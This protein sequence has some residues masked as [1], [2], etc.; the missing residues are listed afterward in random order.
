MPVSSLAR[1]SVYD[2]RIEVVSP[3]SPQL[4]SIQ[5]KKSDSAIALYHRLDISVTDT[6]PESADN[7]RET[8]LSWG[9]DNYR[10][11]PW[12][13]A[14]RSVY[15]VFIAEFFLTQTPADNVADVYPEFLEKYP[16]VEVLHKAD[17]GKIEST[18][19]P[20]GFQ[21]MRTE[22]LTQI[23]SEHDSLPRD[24]DELM[25]LTR[26]GPYVADATLCFA[27]ERPLPILDRNVVRIYRRLFGSAFP[28]SEQS[29]REFATR[30]L[31]EDGSEARRYNLA[32]LDF[33]AKICQK[34][35]PR[36]GECFASDYCS[37]Y[38]SSVRE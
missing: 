11:Y 23:G 15:E 3:P 36:C 32:L 19:E 29:Q 28:E 9:T 27:L 8:L 4:D 31:P 5:S 20:L 25:N 34:R 1:L 21:R 16:S 2:D 13:E 7:F 35:Q 17:P 30:M 26:V 24:R 6:L 37:Y 14:D 12:R 33:A 38:S 18:I 10:W 22:A